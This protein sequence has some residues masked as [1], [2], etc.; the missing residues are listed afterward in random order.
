MTTRTRKVETPGGR[1]ETES[2]D[3]GMSIDAMIG[4]PLD[5]WLRCQ[6]GMLKATEPIAN[7]WIERRRQGANAA[8]DAFEKLA[9]CGDIREAASVQRE[10]FEGSMKRLD[11]DLRAFVEHA[12][13]LSQEAV[14]ATRREA[15]IASAVTSFAPPAPTRRQERTIERAA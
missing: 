12:T 2:A 14:A 15:E 6:A 3:S 9:A 5:T 11:A 13:S 10:W 8:F 1:P 4:W 7:G